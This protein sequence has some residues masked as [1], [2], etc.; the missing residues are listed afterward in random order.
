MESLPF[1]NMDSLDLKDI[2]NCSSES[3]TQEHGKDGGWSDQKKPLRSRKYTTDLL[4]VVQKNVLVSS[5]EKYIVSSTEAVSKLLNILF[6]L[7]F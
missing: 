2:R 6:H 5:V 3:D 4:I 7:L 1:N